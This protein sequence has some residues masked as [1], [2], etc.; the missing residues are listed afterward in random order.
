MAYSAYVIHLIFESEK[1]AT[2]IIENQ[3]H[4]PDLVYSPKLMAKND[5]LCA[6]RL[7]HQCLAVGVYIT[8][9][10]PDE[11][12]TDTAKTWGSTDKRSNVVN[13]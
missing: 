12:A 3:I 10:A 6:K 4:W 13:F 11:F 9:I 2:I 1:C 5:Y 8:G 7:V